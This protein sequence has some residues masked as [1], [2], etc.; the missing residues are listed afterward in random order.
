MEDYGVAGPG[1]PGFKVMKLL[2]DFFPVLLFF[3]AYKADGIYTATAVAIAATIVQLG[4]YWYKFRR[5]ETMHLVTL[6]LLIVFGSATLL[7]HDETFIKWKPT[8]V[9]WLFAMAFV[10]SHLVGK[11]PLIQRIMASSLVLPTAIWLRLNVG[12]TLFFVAMGAINLIVVYNFDTDTWV[13]F[14]LFGN[15]GLTIVFIIGQSFFIARY[16]R[17]DGTINGEH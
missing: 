11:E 17:N 14:K 5:F 7:L 3:I 15:F 4:V 9:N 10:G 6:A 13:N 8:V 12:W 1:R 2:F 16:V